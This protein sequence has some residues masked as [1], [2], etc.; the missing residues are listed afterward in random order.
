MAS[1]S[2]NQ[3]SLSDK[4]TLACTYACLLLH[5]EGL[6]IEAK[7]IKKLL[8]AAN[9]KYEAFWPTIFEKTLKGRNISDLIVSGGSSQGEVS[10]A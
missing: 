8:D 10:T 6:D 5:D 7:S 2:V 9:V 3:L 1:V 4:S